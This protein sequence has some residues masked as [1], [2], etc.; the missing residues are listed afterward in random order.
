MESILII[1][2][3]PKQAR[4]I[5]RG[6]VA[7]GYRCKVIQDTAEGLLYAREQPS[8]LLVLSTRLPWVMCRDL[9]ALCGEMDWPVL[10]LAEEETNAEHLRS[11]LQSKSEVL[12]HPFD[13][14]STLV[15]VKRLLLRGEDALA[16]GEL[17]MD[18]IFQ[19]ATYRGKSLTLT[20]QEFSLL[21][22]L[23]RSPE[24]VIDRGTLLREAWGYQGG[25]D[26]RTVDVHIQR[27]RRKLGKELIET[28]YKQGYKL[29]GSLL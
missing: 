23:L 6:L 19:K 2:P 12:V 21:E 14:L 15:A 3:N 13:P 24:E 5:R 20:S 10:F 8:L 18:L 16:L 27:L 7:G 4:E 22:V 11:L 25:Y 29:V 17:S 28:V 9:L 26:T 1:H